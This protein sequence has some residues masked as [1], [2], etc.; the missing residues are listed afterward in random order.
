MTRRGGYQNVGLEAAMFEGKPVDGLWDV[1]D[2]ADRLIANIESRYGLYTVFYGISMAIVGA[3]LPTLDQAARW[4]DE[5]VL[6]ISE[7]T[8]I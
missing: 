5:H 3:G 7:G 4:V 6:D 8:E 1:R 2:S